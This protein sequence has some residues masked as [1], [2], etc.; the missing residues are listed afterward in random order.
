MRRREERRNSGLRVYKRVIVVDYGI[1]LVPSRNHE[2]K[3]HGGVSSD[4]PPSPFIVDP[5]SP[6][7]SAADSPEGAEV[8][9]ATDAL[10]SVDADLIADANLS[11]DADLLADVSLPVNEG[12][13]FEKDSSSFALLE[14]PLPHSRSGDVAQLSSL[15]HPSQPRFDSSVSSSPGPSQIPTT[16]S[17]FS[18]PQHVITSFPASMVGE[19]SPLGL[20]CVVEE[21]GLGEGEI[22]ESIKEEGVNLLNDSAEVRRRDSTEITL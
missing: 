8:D 22:V 14:Y 10:L 9:L 12:G 21:E 20:S 15:Q 17:R 16:L 3:T 4:P 7:R 5:D 18:L 2:R 13:S 19:S 11:E 1:N 6:P